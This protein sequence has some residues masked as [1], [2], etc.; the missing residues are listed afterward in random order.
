MRDPTGYPTV[1]THL[2][3]G[4]GQ[5]LRGIDPDAD[6]TSH[7]GSGSRNAERMGST[8]PLR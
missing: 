1:L 7:V 4:Q 2:S 6:A 5:M 3:R 8:T